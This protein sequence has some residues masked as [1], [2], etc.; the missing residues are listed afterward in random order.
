MRNKL[1]AKDL[2]SFVSACI[3]KILLNIILEGD[4]LPNQIK[5]TVKKLECLYSN[6][7]TEYFLRTNLKLSLLLRQ[8][9]LALLT[10]DLTGVEQ[11]F[12]MLVVIRYFYTYS[13]DRKYSAS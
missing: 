8:I 7:S 2:L 10:M 1:D 11:K 6:Q 12:L 4:G 3:P 5:K 13:F 9:L